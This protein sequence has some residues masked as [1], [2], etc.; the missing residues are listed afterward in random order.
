[1]RPYSKGSE[2]KVGEARPK[3]VHL[4]NSVEPR[5]PGQRRKEREEVKAQRRAIKKAVRGELK[6]QL[7]SDLEEE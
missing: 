6:K 3:I 2:R 5:N 1:M 7:A 4:A